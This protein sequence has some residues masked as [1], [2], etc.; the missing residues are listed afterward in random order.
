[1][2]SSTSCSAPRPSSP[3]P[4]S[5]YQTRHRW[6]LDLVRGLPEA[7]EQLRALA[8]ELVAAHDAGWELAEPMRG[9]HVSAVRLSR[10]QRGCRTPGPPRTADVVPAPVHRWRLR[11]VDDPPPAAGEQ[12]FDVGSAPRTSVLEWTGTVLEH[13]SGPVVDAGVLA[14][15]IRQ[16][17]PTGLGSRLWGVAPARVGPCLDLVAEGSVLRLHAVEDGALVRTHETLTF[18]HAADGAATLLQAAAAYG[19]LASAAQAMTRAG[20]RLVGADDGLL[21]VGYPSS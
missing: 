3:W 6:Q 20:G 15:V 18:Q 5:R 8:G 12:V 7:A 1:M 4:G 14:E 16:V 10:R 13:L 9:G 19:R 21:H 2:S 17:A 11:V